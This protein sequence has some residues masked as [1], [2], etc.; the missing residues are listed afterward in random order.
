MVKPGREE[1][2]AIAPIAERQV[3]RWAMRLES[4]ERIAPDRMVARLPGMIH[5]YVAISREAGAGGGEV[6]H[7][8]AAQLGCECLDNELLTY[9]AKRYGL[10]EGLL[11]LVDETASTWLHETV[12]LW[13]DRRAI[14]QD[15]YVMHVGQ[16]MLLAARE[17]TAVFVGRGA[18]FVL[19]RDRGLAVRLIAPVE[20]R[21]ARTMERRKLARDDAAARVRETDA[22]R[23]LL[24]RRQF[25]ADIADPRLYDVVLNLE[26]LEHGA[27]ADVIV[28]AFR[29]RFAVDTTGSVGPRTDT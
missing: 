11:R 5:P 10:P 29:R 27:A 22:G 3:R 21:I 18:Q 15:E 25:R 24:V 23:A 13:L 8:V 9:V 16:L 4:E 14:T 26:H 28:T 17:S 1:L 19:P 2:R 6:G 7:A 12:R 20:Q